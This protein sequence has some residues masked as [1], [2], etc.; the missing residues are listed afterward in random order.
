[1]SWR[2]HPF[3]FVMATAFAF[4]TLAFP[5][6]AGSAQGDQITITL[7]SSNLNQAAYQVLIANFERVYPNI[8]VDGTY[9]LNSTIAQLEPTELASGNAPDLLVSVPGC[10]STDS[11]CVLAKAGELAPMLT[12]PW[13]KR[14]LPLVTSLNKYGRGLFGFEPSLTFEGMFTN[15][16][17]F[18]KLGLKVPQTFSQLLDVCQK[19]KADGTFAVFLPGLNT[20]TVQQFVED[21]AIPYVYGPDKHW[22]AEQRAGKVS[23]DGSAGWHRALQEFVDMSNAGCF[24]P[25]MT[26]TAA[27]GQFPA[28]QGLMDPGTASLKG[29][30]DAANPQFS[31]SFHPFPGRS[32]SNAAQVFVTLSDDLSINAH[33]SAA[34]Q[35][36][37]QTFVNFVARPKQNAL[38]SQIRGSLT[39]YQ[40]LHQ[41]LP[42]DMPTLAPVV[43]H[44]QY[45]INPALS[46]WNAN[47][48]LVM[49]QDAIGLI[50]GQTT[51]DGMLS[52]MDAAW[53]QG[54]T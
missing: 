22:A 50:T 2:R 51:I 45:V 46:W 12:V 30:I 18:Q 37:A 3:G 11:I 23:F 29:L 14:S 6:A 19:A 21:L 43:Q 40:F 16:T 25:G 53:R 41:Q 33:S 1:M 38:Y 15:D 28:G 9:L 8:T 26:G 24:E 20:Q 32:T 27:A 4:V 17:Q 39:Q 36:A 5:G 54:P 47:V 35:A 13:A 7:L 52:A 42:E 10:G 48:Q 49:Q 44:G 31:Y 34:A